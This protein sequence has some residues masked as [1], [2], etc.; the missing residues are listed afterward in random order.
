MSEEL[1]NL[2]K[3]LSFT[4]EEQS[5][6]FI[7]QDWVDKAEEV[8]KKCL[9]GKLVLI[10]RANV[11]VMKNVLSTVWK[12]SSGLIVKEVEIRLYVFQFESNV[13]KERVLLK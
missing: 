10:K 6:V 3:K 2:W 9:I 7:E 5:K 4:K 8:G 11:E 13:K 12:I 1:E